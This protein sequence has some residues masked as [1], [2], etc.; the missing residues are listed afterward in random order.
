MPRLTIRDLAA[1]SGVSVATVNR[2]LAGKGGVHEATMRR[3]LDAAREIGFHGVRALAHRVDAARTRYRFALIVQ[4]PHR[5]FS[6]AVARHLE[7]AA[8]KATD[9]EVEIRSELIDDLSPDGVADMMMALGAESDGLALIAAEHPLVTDAIDRLTGQG[10][11]IIAMVSPLLARSSVGYVGLDSWKVGRTAAW[12][13]HKMCRGPGEL[14]LLVGTHRYRC[15]DLYESGFRSYFREHA[16]D[17]VVLEA[18]STF[19]SDAIA[20]ELAEQLLDRHANLRG[21]YVS[22]GGIAGV[23]A[24]VRDVGRHRE[25]V[26]A[27][28]DLMESTRSGLIDGTLTLVISHPFQAI[29]QE[30]LTALLQARRGRAGG[31]SIIVPFDIFTRE[32]L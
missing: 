19:E 2:V 21:I 31:Q 22:G 15:H 32:N 27:G 11:P 26:I 17:L 30:T 16:G 4:T 23:L 3:V 18:M 9:A 5:P 28:H 10:V 24:A 25:L 1:K 20:R 29:A 14:G 7:S 6:T 13:L 8:A 12:A